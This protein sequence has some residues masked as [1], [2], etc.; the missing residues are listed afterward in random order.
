MEDQV[1]DREQPR[2]DFYQKAVIVMKMVACPIDGVCRLWASFPTFVGLRQP[3]WQCEA[4][5]NVLQL[6]R[7]RL[8]S[9]I[10]TVPSMKVLGELASES[11]DKLRR[12]ECS[13]SSTIPAASRRHPARSI[14]SDNSC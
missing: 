4:S 7:W 2:V 12:T 14:T 8:L 5:L 6:S 10:L 11:S 1:P 13:E 9:D 3:F